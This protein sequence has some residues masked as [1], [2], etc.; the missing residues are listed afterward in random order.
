MHPGLRKVFHS[1][2]AAVALITKAEEKLVRAH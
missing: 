1:E 2:S